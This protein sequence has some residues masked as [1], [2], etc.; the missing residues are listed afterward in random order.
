MSR[1]GCLADRSSCRLSRKS[2]KRGV[3]LGAPIRARHPPIR[4]HLSARNRG[5]QLERPIA[6]LLHQP[7]HHRVRLVH[8][9]RTPECGRALPGQRPGVSYGDCSPGHCLVHDGQHHAAMHVAGCPGEGVS[10]AELGEHHAGLVVVNEADSQAG[11]VGGLADEAV[12]G[13][14][15]PSVVQPMQA[16]GPRRY[17]APAKMAADGPPAARD[18]P[19]GR[20]RAI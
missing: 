6:A 1:P 5:A 11:S 13:E 19:S 4:W 10:Q 2:H 9:H 15:P 16:H 8:Q 12:G 17:S 7:R 20:C 3:G 18:S 14:A